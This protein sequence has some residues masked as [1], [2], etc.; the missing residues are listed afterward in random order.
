MRRT[1]TERPITARATAHA[2]RR[3][4]SE[5]GRQDRCTMRPVGYFAGAF[6]A[7]TGPVDGPAGPTFGSSAGFVAVGSPQPTAAQRL[8]KQR[9]SVARIRILFRLII[10]PTPEDAGSPGYGVASTASSWRLMW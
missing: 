1:N 3:R 9:K 6:S 2:E 7:G 4:G 10:P 5:Q 8:I